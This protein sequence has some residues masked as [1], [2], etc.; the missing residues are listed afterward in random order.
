MHGEWFQ[1]TPELLSFIESIKMPSKN[2]V[3]EI[4]KN[5]F[6]IIF[7]KP[8]RVSIE[9]IFA[10]GASEIKILGDE[11][12]QYAFGVEGDAETLLELWQNLVDKKAL[13]ELKQIMF[14]PISTPR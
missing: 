8:I 7:V 9:F 4:N 5:V 2:E 11:E 12:T 14:P 1:P 3:Y 10:L 6:R 13:E